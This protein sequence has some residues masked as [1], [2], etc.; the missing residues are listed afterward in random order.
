MQAPGGVDQH[1]VHGARTRR[2]DRVVSDRPRVLARAAAHDL[3][4]RPLGPHHELVDGGGAI[5]VGCRQQHARTA[6]AAQ[7][8][9]ELADRGRFARAVDADEHHDSRLRAQIEAG[10]RP[11]GHQRRG[12]QVTQ[13]RSDIAAVDIAGSHLVFELLDEPG[14]RRNADVGPDERLL[15]ALEE[16]VVDAAEDARAELALQRLAGLA[17]ALSQ[18]RKQAFAARASRIPLARPHSRRQKQRLAPL[19]RHRGRQLTRCAW[20]ARPQGTATGRRNQGGP[21]QRSRT[22]CPAGAR[23]PQRCAECRADHLSALASAALSQRRRDGRKFGRRSR[24]CADRPVACRRALRRTG[25]PLGA[26]AA[27]GRAAGARRPARCRR[28]PSI[29]RRECRRRPSCASGG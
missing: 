14:C 19:D 4:S 6:L 26:P 24:Q 9:G 18:A 11:G 10:V 21:R 16:S 27:G 5:G 23:S 1:D 28:A 3:G 20:V 8:R 15:Q 13:T 25:Q 29:R 22:R 2:L 12:D 7:R 17:Q